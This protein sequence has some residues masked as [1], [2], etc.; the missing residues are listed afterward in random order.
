MR[1]LVRD[2]W[3]CQLCGANRKT[4]PAIELQVDHRIP[5]ALSKDN[6][7]RNLQTL[8][9]DCNLGKKAHCRDCVKQNCTNCNLAF[10]K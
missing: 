1:V 9:K 2:D 5:F 7:E 6:S 10:Q 3:T 8:C 4:N